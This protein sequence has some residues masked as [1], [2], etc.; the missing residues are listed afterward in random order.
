LND[1][2]LDKL[3]EISLGK[4]EISTDTILAEMNIP[5]DRQTPQI[6]S[7]INQA[8]I[9][10]GYYSCRI[11]VSNKRKRGFKKHDDQLILNERVEEI[12]SW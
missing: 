10:L 12:P 5:V 3:T 6:Q 4:K 1:V 7:R 9:S 11:S 8:M 2:W